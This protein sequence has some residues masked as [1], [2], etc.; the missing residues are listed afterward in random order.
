M[1]KEKW[2]DLV[3]LNKRTLSCLTAPKVLDLLAGPEWREKILLKIPVVLTI[4]KT[5]NFITKEE[6]VYLILFGIKFCIFHKNGK[7]RE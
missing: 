5:K 7:A 2:I 6:K 4:N 3:S 1:P